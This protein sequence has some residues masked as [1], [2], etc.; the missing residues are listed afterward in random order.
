MACS[1][2]HTSVWLYEA[3]TEQVR[4]LRTTC[5]VGVWNE[6]QNRPVRINPRQIMTCHKA[7]VR[8]RMEYHLLLPTAITCLGMV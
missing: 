7:A 4:H 5:G 1:I 6:A 8:I 3:L 2:A